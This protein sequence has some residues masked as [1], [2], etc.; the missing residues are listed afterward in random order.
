M[1]GRRRAAPRSTSSPGLSP[2]LGL[3]ADMRRDVECVFERDPAARSKA[4]VAIL[5]S[6]L[7][8]VWAHRVS[9]ALWRRDHLFSARAISQAARALTGIEIHPGATLG[10]GLFIDHGMG[11]VIGETAE[12]GED[13]TIYHGVTLGG[14]STEPGKRHPTV[15]DRVTIGAGAKV[16]GPIEVGHDSRIGGNAVLVRPV[17]ENSVVVGVPGQV[18]ARTKP[19]TAS[20][21]PDLEHANQPDLI[22]AAVANLLERVDSLEYSVTGHVNEFHLHATAPGHWAEFEDFSI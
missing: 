2:A 3:L 19:H 15:G 22:G 17:A 1:A 13:C 7:H 20:D 12:V 9:N 14:T 18:I 21:K 11:V 16:L 6:G 10:S 5:Y 8:A 4:E